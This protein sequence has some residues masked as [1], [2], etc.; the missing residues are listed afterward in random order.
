[1]KKI[2][3]LLLAAAVGAAT[4]G[5]QQTVFIG[6]TG[7]DDLPSAVAAAVSGDVIT[8][9]GETV[10][11]K[12]VDFGAEKD[13]EL[14][15]K[16]ENNAV[17]KR[18]GDYAMFIMRPKNKYTFENLTFDGE[19]RNKLAVENKQ[20]NTTL[21]L[22]DC[23][24]VNIPGRAVQT[25]STTVLTNVDMSTCKTGD[26]DGALFVGANNKVTL[27]GTADYSVYLES[28]YSIAQGEN[29]SGKVDIRLQTYAPKTLVKGVTAETAS[30]Y[31]ITGAPV[32]F[33]LQFDNGNLNLVSFKAVVRNETTGE[34]YSTLLE[35][36]NA[37]VAPEEGEVVLSV[38]E[39]TTL[40]D[41]LGSQKFPIVI[42]GANA[43]VV[44][45]KTFNNKLFVS[46]NANLTFENLVLDC[47]NANGGFANEFE[48][49][50]NTLSF[51]NVK[52]TNCNATANVFNV[53]EG[54]RTLNLDN[55]TGENI[56]APMGV[57]LNGKLRLNGNTNFNVRIA[58]AGASITAA[59]ELTNEAPIEIS[60]ADGITRND[61]D[62]IVNGT[63][64]AAKFKLTNGKFLNAVEGNLVMSTTEQTGIEDLE[65]EN[66]APVYYNLNGVEVANPAQGIYLMKRGS[67]VTKVV[68]K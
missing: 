52:I 3:T 60:F 50:Q 56:T 44:V 38:L 65:A 26:T 37:A 48:A 40:T 47:N 14:T 53:K 27:V 1:M 34:T 41:R 29:F 31:T 11:N 6:T 22:K 16:G 25:K 17:I 30:C 46:N 62:V 2:Y 66:A 57:N 15:F 43:D 32:D 8:I 45:K 10:L 21:N 39:S 54:T 20:T 55:C 59:G 42:K 18:G 58:N 28:N 68:V 5:A 35:A 19:N 51:V 23:K 4:A 61:G 12:R 64:Q 9:K 33:K 49:N 36:Y 7:Y 24:F 13:I 63:E 67:K